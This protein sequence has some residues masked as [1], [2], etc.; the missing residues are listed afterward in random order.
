MKV[1]EAIKKGFSA[2]TS[3]LLIVL[4]V[5]G[6]SLVFNLAMSPL[7]S[8]LQALTQEWGSTPAIRQVIPALPYLALF[9]VLT[10][11]LNTAITAGTFG[12]VLEKLKNG[13]ASIQ[14]FFNSGAKFFPRFLGLVALSFAFGLAFFVL[15]ILSIF[16][17]ALISNIGANAGVWLGLGVAVAII[18][19]LALVSAWVY[20]M[21]LFFTLAPYRMVAKDAGL[22]ASIK[23]S[24]AIVKKLFWPVVGIVTILS[25]VFLL[26]ALIVFVAGF[27]I[28]NA[29]GNPQA[30]QGSGPLSI[31]L[32]VVFGFLFL[33]IDLFSKS[34]LMSFYLGN[35]D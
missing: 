20:W 11:L 31:G 1:A 14:T 2:A 12:Y 24:S 30:L 8:K 16:V 5:L 6:V 7:S 35:S 28:A 21:F 9:V 10:T 4:V 34:S 26:F 32:S 29:T 13:K 25:L 17:A 22:M 23:E 19:I 18:L 27:V 15:I 33:F 3:S